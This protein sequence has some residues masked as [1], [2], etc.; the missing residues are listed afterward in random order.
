MKQELLW[1]IFI[2]FLGAFTVHSGD[3]KNEDQKEITCSTHTWNGL[4]IGGNSLND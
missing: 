3:W 4:H 2:Y 1:S